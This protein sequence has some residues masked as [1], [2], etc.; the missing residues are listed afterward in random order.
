M[1]IKAAICDLDGTLLNTL[2]DIAESANQ[3][4]LNHGYPKIVS[5]KYKELIGKGAKNLIL[6]ITPEE[7]AEPEIDCLVSEFK[8]LYSR[9]LCEKTV[10]YDGVDSLLDWFDELGILYAVLS[11]KPHHLTSQIISHYFPDRKFKAVIGQQKDAPMKP[12]PECVKGILECLQ[13]EPGEVVFIGDSGLDM[14]TA[15]NAKMLGVGVLWG[16]RDQEELILHGAKRLV[17]NP[18]E[19]LDVIDRT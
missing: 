17:T 9:R 7:I 2:D 18:L 12:N 5:E 13:C 3:V 6:C 8:D 4:L 11:N 15:N 1:I 14:E 19:I 10:K 16:Y